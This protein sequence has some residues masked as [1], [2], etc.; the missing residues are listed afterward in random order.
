M[1]VACILCFFSFSFNGELYQCAVVH[2]FDQVGDRPDEATGMWTIRPSS[3]PHRQHNIAVI[4]IDSIYQA[5]HLIPIYGTSPV[6]LVVPPNRSYDIFHTFYVNK[7]ADHH[8]F[9]I[10][11]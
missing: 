7:F 5:A 4:H 9:E 10:A 8:V 6:P 1:D 2:W 3:T 11:F